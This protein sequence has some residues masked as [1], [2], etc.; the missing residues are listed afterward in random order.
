MTLNLMDLLQSVAGVQ[1]PQTSQPPETVDN[2]TIQSVGLQ[3]APAQINPA[4]AANL[5]AGTTVSPEGAQALQIAQGLPERKGLFGMKGTLRDVVGSIGDALLMSKGHDPVYA[6]HR[7]QERIADAMVGFNSKTPEDQQAAIQRVAFIDPNAGMKLQDAYE[8]QQYR[9]KQLKATEAYKNALIGNQQSKAQAVMLKDSQ[10]T[11]AGINGAI[12]KYGETPSLVAL[13]DKYTNHVANLLGI[14]D[15]SS[16]TPMSPDEAAAMAYG[17]VTPSGQI[18]DAN[19]DAA[20]TEKADFD[21]WKKAHPRAA[22]APKP[23][24]TKEYLE[25]KAASGKPLTPAEQKVYN[26]MHPQRKAKFSVPPVPAGL[27]K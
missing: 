5:A 19:S 22:A 15:P 7:H 27:F 1:T 11:L 13:R 25:S 3:P 12:A 14:D 4:Y 8:Q 24:S 18:R 23:V 26:D 16:I 17:G 9:D 10:R 6:P 20:L 21:A 2:R